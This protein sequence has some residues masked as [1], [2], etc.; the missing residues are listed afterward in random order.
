MAAD[1]QFN[2]NIGMVTISTANSNLDGTGTLGTVL[3]AG[4]GTVGSSSGTLIKSITIKA[5]ANTS[6]GMV[7]F[8][9]TSGANTRLISEVQV[10]AV[11]KS[12]ST[13]S[14]EVKVDTDYVLFAG[15]VL[16]ASTQNGD[17]FNIIAEGIDWNYSNVGYAEI[18]AVGGGGGGGD[19]TGGGG[20]AGGL[21]HKTSYSIKVQSYTVTVGAG[22]TTVNNSNGTNGGNSVF[23]TLTATGGGFG[24]SNGTG[25]QENGANGGSGGGGGYLGTGG[26]GTAGQGNGGGAGSSSPINAAG[27][28]GAGASGGSAGANAGNGGNG[29]SVSISGAAVYYGG[30]G[31][32]GRYVTGGANGTGGS[33]GGGNGGQPGTAGTANTGGGG[34]GGAHNT[35]GASG[36]GG[37][38]IVIISYPIGTI[39]ATG[40][41]ITTAG[42]RKIH[43]FTASGTFAVSSI[44]LP[45]S[46]NYQ[47]NTGTVVISTANS[48]LNG[49]GTLGTII[50][51]GVSGSGFV[52]TRIKSVTIK[53]QANTTDG[54]IRLFIQDAAGA[55]TL[56]LTEISVLAITQS[57]KTQSFYN[58]V[59]F[60]GD[61]IV[62]SPGY[63]LMA[64]TEI[65]Q[66]FMVTAEGLDLK[67]PS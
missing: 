15:N 48:N 47:L 18:L 7:R 42:G 24:G 31:G 3:M 26:S 25:A 36:A 32:G 61:G 19:F 64:S 38:G 23:D 14:F 5:Q 65:A 43:T 17:T 33:G 62:L 29:I 11:I 39:T 63:K 53:A 10:P 35:N 1:T 28:G 9:I 8:F 21:I 55:N 27:G 30:G 6:L 41:T 20:G 66:T 57:A 49:T 56:L 34:G 51:A 52:G 59:N 44:V 22:G 58:V 60:K 13:P 67:Y 40:G 54:M 37:S 2:P 45:E 50:T 16:K 4:S 12:A 46:S